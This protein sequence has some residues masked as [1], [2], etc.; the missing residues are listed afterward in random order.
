MR[1][2]LFVTGAGSVT[3][4]GLGL[5]ALGRA[6]AGE[7]PFAQDEPIAGQAVP[8]GRVGRLNDSVSANSYERWGQ[9]DTYSR[10]GFAAARLALSDAGLA[11]GDAALSD[12]GVLL[13]TA[14]G[15]IEENQRFDRYSAQDGSLKG[16]S[17]LLF[18]GTVDNAPAGWIAVAWKLRGPNATFVSG[19]GAALEALW[20][21]DGVLRE[22]RATGLLVGG[23]ERFV[24][25]HHILRERDPARQGEILSEGAGIVLVERED[26]LRRRGLEPSESRAELVAVARFSGELESARQRLFEE[27]GL[28]EA[29]VGL[30]LLA[31]PSGLKS[32]LG[33][34]HGAWGGLAL[35]AALQC[36]NDDGWSGRPLAVVHAF[37]EGQ[38]HFF[39]VLK[40]PTEEA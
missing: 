24:D 4:A 40:H 34:P 22:D 19:D 35:C 31:E 18:K 29:D 21:A 13:G 16:A 12:M 15:C 1:E 39:A 5:E 11:L 27:L 36:R 33:E 32:R 9:L 6:A 3:W 20:S 25:L 23:V 28:S 38:E 37:G 14:Y 17:P 30:T 8:S 7:V 26:A 10:Y 2:R